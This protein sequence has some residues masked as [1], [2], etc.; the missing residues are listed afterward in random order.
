MTKIKIVLIIPLVIILAKS[1]TDR[2]N[3]PRQNS[4]WGM[5]ACLFS[6]EM[7]MVSV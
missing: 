5:V 7:E 6:G 4:D 2:N 1:L 3:S